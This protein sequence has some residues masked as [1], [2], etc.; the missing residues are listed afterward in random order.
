MLRTFATSFLRNNLSS[1][2]GNKIY[3]TMR[4]YVATPCFSA[5]ARSSS[6]FDSSRMARL[7]QTEDVGK[8]KPG[9]EGRAQVGT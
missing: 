5:Y 9:A 4:V 8:R 3:H 2:K 1:I 6:L 7:L